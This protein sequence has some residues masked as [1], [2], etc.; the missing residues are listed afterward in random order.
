MK[1]YFGSGVRDVKI[2]NV[3]DGF[4]AEDTLAPTPCL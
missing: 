1:E 4:I 3:P 2:T